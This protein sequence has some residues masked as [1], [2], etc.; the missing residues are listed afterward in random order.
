MNSTVI[1]AD[2]LSAT[3]GG[4]I[5]GLEVRDSLWAAG[6]Q[7]GRQAELLGRKKHNMCPPYRG[8]VD[9]SRDTTQG[10]PPSII[11]KTNII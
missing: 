11:S 4:G 1:S 8:L 6:K 2:G 9:S 3:F 7:T 10:T 5:L